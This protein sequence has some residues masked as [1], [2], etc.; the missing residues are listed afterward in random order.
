M[1]LYKCDGYTL[2][3]NDSSKAIVYYEDKLLFM[4]DSRTAIK[5]FCQNCS[6]EKLRTK[7]K[8]YKYIKIWD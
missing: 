5:F 1:S 4:G 7:L 2:D 8:K 3:T 6:D